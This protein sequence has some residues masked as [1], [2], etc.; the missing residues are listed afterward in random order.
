MFYTAL[1]SCCI[2]IGR[3][4]MTRRNWSA[5]SL[6][7]LVAGGVVLLGALPAGAA[8]YWKV[9]AGDWSPAA[10]WGGALPTYNDDAYIINS[11]SG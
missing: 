8:I 7:V 3:P 2:R 4:A 9:A 1:H 6:M 5:V 11:G 10:N